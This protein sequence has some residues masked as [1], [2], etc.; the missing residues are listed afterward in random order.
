[1]TEPNDCP[2]CAV[3]AEIG[4]DETTCRECRRAIDLEREGII[5]ERDDWGT[6]RRYAR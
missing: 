6:L 1:V 3:L 4:A 5:A 2:L